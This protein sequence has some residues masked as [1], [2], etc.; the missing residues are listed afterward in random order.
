MDS[1]DLNELS[2]GRADDEEADDVSA[3]SVELA[4]VVA[5]PRALARAGCLTQ[6]AHAS[7]AVSRCN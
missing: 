5:P 2:H 4:V 1:R 6:G 3:F 7:R